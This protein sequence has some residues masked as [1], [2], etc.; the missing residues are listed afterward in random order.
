MKNLNIALGGPRSV[1]AAADTEVG[2]PELLQVSHNS[3]LTTHHTMKLKINE[4]NLELQT[5]AATNQK[6]VDDYAKDMIEGLE[7]DPV[8][9]FRES[10]DAY[11]I[12]LV[13]GFHRVYATQKIGLDEIEANIIYGTHGSA[14][15]YALKVNADH[16]LQRTNKD[17][18]KALQIAWENRDILIPEPNGQD[19]NG[20]PNGLPSAR[21]LAVICGVSPRFAAYFIEIQRVML[22]HT[23]P[24]EATE[25]APEVSAFTGKKLAFTGDDNGTA[26][27]ANFHHT[28]ERNAT[29]RQLLKE[30]KDRY[31]VF[32]PERI[33]P[34]F[35]S[36]APKD[37]LVDLGG[38]RKKLDDRRLEGDIAFTQFI[39]FA[40]RHLDNMIRSVRAG[41]PHCVCRICQG[42]GRGCSAC[43]ELGFQTKGQFDRTAKDFKPENE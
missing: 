18:Q 12:Y 14:L 17:K 28:E 22:M 16:G 43:S 5:R 10:K 7:F 2:P 30:N 11:P 38:I 24:S 8:I 33:R 3:S 6:K 29:R 36:T 40:M 4:L 19:E 34:A 42:R 26:V 27:D 39:P 35:L 23:P 41:L 9:V 21:Q 13:D 1:A 37:L 20:K 31:G 15:S 32:I 25:K